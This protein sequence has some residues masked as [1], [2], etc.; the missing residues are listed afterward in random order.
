M[1]RYAVR[2]IETRATECVYHVDANDPREAESL[3]LSGAG[4]MDHEVPHS[5]EILDRN[6]WDMPAELED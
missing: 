4:E 2:V 3:A 5:T 1:P 6:V